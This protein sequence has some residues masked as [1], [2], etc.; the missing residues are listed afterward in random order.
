M[1]TM[2][3]PELIKNFVGAGKAILTLQSAATNNH[4]TYRVVK[5]DEKPPFVFLLTGGDQEFTY[6]GMIGRNGFQ[7]TGKSRL[8]DA[9]PS[10]KAFKY[11]Y[12]NVIIAGKIPAQ[13]TVRHE[14]KCA[15]CGRPLTHPESID[16]G[17]GPECIKHVH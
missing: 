17:F 11:F 7:L 4:Y 6:L 10:V 13:L 2:T 1:T 9:A 12:N 5:K 14:G 8:T 3:N 15:R 16:T